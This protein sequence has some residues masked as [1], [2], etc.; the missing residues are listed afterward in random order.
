ML[1]C[2][3]AQNITTVRLPFMLFDVL[4]LG[5]LSLPE[6]WKDHLDPEHLM[7]VQQSVGDALWGA[8]DTMIADLL[9]ALQ[10]FLKIIGSNVTIPVDQF[11]QAPGSYGRVGLFRVE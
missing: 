7:F 8:N 1:E 4:G 3:L 11:D 6:F 2:C 9:E 5:V 10:E